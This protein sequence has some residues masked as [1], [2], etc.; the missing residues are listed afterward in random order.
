MQKRPLPEAFVMG[1]FRY[2]FGVGHAFDLHARTTAA[3]HVHILAPRPH[4]GAHHAG[5]SVEESDIII[6][7]LHLFG[8]GAVGVGYRFDKRHPQPVGFIAALV[9]NIPHFAAGVFFEAELDQAYF[10]VFQRDLSL[11][12]D[13]GGA[14]ET[15]RDAA[16]EV[17]LAGDVHLPDDVQFR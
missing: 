8:V 15:G 11:H 6:G 13:D 7:L 17:L 14:L 2:P 4:A 3:A 1:Q 10:L 9:T 12:A 5:A 16:V